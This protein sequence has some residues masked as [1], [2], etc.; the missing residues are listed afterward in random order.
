V[1]EEMVNL[2]AQQQAYSAAARLLTTA[3]DMMQTLLQM[4]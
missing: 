2:I 4:V 3:N 1:D